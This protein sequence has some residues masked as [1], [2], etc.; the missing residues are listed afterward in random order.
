MK[1]IY[2]S[3]P[4]SGLDEKKVREHADLVKSKLSKEG[5]RPVSPFEIYA[6]KK[7]KYND[8]LAS[9]IRAL[10]DCDGAY[11]CH[12]WKLSFGCNVEHSIAMQM[13]KRDMDNFRM[14]YECE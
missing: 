6:G 12:G 10:L 5:Y 2:I 8:H 1:K 9:D 7:P 11:F 3:I 4:I 13:K 14:M